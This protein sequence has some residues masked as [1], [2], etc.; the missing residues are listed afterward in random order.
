MSEDEYDKLD[1]NA[2]AYQQEE[3]IVKSYQYK[4]LNSIVDLAEI[5]VD[6]II[7]EYVHR[8]LKGCQAERSKI[9]IIDFTRAF[10]KL[11]EKQLN[12]DISN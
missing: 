9:W 12:Y 4:L 3:D 8:N 6:V 2:H 11:K 5:D 10:K 7:L 1:L